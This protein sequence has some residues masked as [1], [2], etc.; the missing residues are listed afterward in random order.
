MSIA[1]TAGTFIAKRALTELVKR[2]RRATPQ[3]K[4]E[5][6]NDEQFEQLG[7]DNAQSILVLTARID[8]TDSDL[9]HMGNRVEEVAQVV[10]ELIDYQAALIAEQYKNDPEHQPA[11]EDVENLAAATTKAY[12]YA[13]SDEKREIIWTAFNSSFNPRFY[14]D[15]LYK[16]LWRIVDKL[17]Y[18]HFRVLKDLMDGNYS[19][20]LPRNAEDTFFAQE[21]ASLDLL[22]ETSVP[23]GNV[24]LEPAT[25][26]Y[27]LLEFATP[28][29]VSRLPAGQAG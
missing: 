18:P 1:A 20:G 28:P 4:F 6:E 29:K 26:A 16:I 19:S 17:E 22:L 24:G 15:G 13:G 10:S 25:I 7:V 5:S 21:L 3:G 2:V 23:N 9:A 12:Y 14:K 11:Q 27:K 8:A